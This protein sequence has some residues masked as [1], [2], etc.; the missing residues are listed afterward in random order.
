[1]FWES[2]ILVTLSPI[3]IGCIYNL[4]RTDHKSRK[5]ESHF[6][7]GQISGQLLLVAVS[8]GKDLQFVPKLFQNEEYSALKCKALTSL[9]LGKQTDSGSSITLLADHSLNSIM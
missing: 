4:V 6:L 2:A 8:Q 3:G 5:N 1:M 7:G 9:H